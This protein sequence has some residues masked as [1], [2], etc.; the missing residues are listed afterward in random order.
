MKIDTDLGPLGVI[1]L[2][3]G[4]GNGLRA[5]IEGSYRS[6][7]ISSIATLR[8]N[9][10]TLP[11]TNASGSAETYAVMANFAFDI[12]V[13][14]FGWPVQP[15]IGAG[16]G[17]G[18]L[19]F[20]NAQGNGTTTFHLPD[21]NTFG[22]GP[23]LV[24]FGSAGAFA[25]QAIVGMSLPLQFCQASMPRWSTVSSAWRAPISRSPG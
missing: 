13:H 25:Y 8:T 18:W 5:E 21:D 24:S 3:W 1:A 14:R 20:N 19:N 7:G 23:D 17:Y 4:F 6:N 15:Y 16:V 11:L 2:G 10:R 12:P 9:G 22:P